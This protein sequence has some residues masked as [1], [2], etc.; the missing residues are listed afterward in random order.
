[1]KIATATELRA[2]KSAIQSRGLK[3]KWL[4]QKIGVSQP[5]IS[6]FL[7]GERNLS[8]PKYVALSK[9]LGV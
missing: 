3:K 5:T 1:M 8:E 6:L 4:A 7:N 2:I 9:L